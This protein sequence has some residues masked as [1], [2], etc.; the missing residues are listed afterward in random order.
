MIR[1]VNMTTKLMTLIRL[2]M[3][4][5]ESVDVEGEESEDG[6]LAMHTSLGS[7]TG[8]EKYTITHTPTGLAI[9]KDIWSREKA[10][11][12][13]RAIDGWEEWETLGGK[14]DVTEGLRVKFRETRKRI[15]LL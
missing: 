2:K 15:G 11:N 5:G 9:M 10:R 8:N 4:E 13:M 6:L 1:P 3:K 7:V 14:G 12:L